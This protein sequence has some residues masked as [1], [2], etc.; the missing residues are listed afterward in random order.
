MVYSQRFH[1]HC[2]ELIK[3]SLKFSFTLKAGRNNSCWYQ[4]FS[5]H[6]SK[7]SP[8]LDALASFATTP[9]FWFPA[10]RYFSQIPVTFI[11][12]P[13]HLWFSSSTRSPCVPNSLWLSYFSWIS[14]D[15]HNFPKSAV[16]L[17]FSDYFLQICSWPGALCK[18]N[19]RIGKL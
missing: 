5:H 1:P 10:L 14:C 18:L 11:L 19:G 16:T 9:R 7:Y 12:F 4:R 17:I 6:D 15:F 3:R 2:K 8:F 13:N